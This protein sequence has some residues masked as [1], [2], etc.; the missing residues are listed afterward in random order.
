MSFVGPIVLTLPVA[1]AALLTAGS[2]TG[3]WVTLG[4]ATAY[5]L[6]LLALGVALGGRR[7]DRK[8]PEVLGQLAHAQL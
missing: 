4:L 1:V 5:G 6:G 3:R 7:L 2:T 8:S